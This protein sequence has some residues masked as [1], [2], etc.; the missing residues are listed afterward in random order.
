[1]IDVSSSNDV[2]VGQDATSEFMIHEYK[3]FVGANSSC[4]LHWEGQTTL[5]P[6]VS[7]VYLQIYNRD[8]TTWDTVDSDNASLADADFLLVA[9]VAD[10]T[11]YKDVGNLVSCRI[12]QEAI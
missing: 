7:T 1:V 11:D 10:L 5:E 4:Q 2:L 12:Y 3:N 6:N 9:D 8:T